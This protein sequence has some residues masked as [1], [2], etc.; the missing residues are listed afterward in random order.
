M[1]FCVQGVIDG[2]ASI[3]GENH[4]DLSWMNPEICRLMIELYRQGYA[5]SVEVWQDEK[6]VGGLYGVSLG[7]YFTIE[8]QFSFIKDTSKVMKKK[9]SF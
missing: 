3:T 2:C 8:S 7:G 1:Y 4:R 5:H 6:L 9:N